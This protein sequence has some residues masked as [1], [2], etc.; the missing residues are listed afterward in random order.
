MRFRAK[1]NDIDC[2]HNFT[3]VM[4]TVNKILKVCV[5]RLTPE[6]IFFILPDQITHGG[7]SMWCELKQAN[8]F[9]VYQLDGY[10]SN[11]NE[12]Y[13]EVVAEN[14]CRALKS[15]SNA[16][17]L[18]IRLSRKQVPCLT[19]EIELPSL[20]STARTVTHDVPVSVIPR[21]LWDDFQEPE[22]PDFHVCVCMPPLQRVKNVVERLK[23]LSTYL[24]IMANQN[25]DMALQVE[26]ELVSARTTFRSL[27]IPNVPDENSQATSKL[28]SKDEFACARIDI[29]KFLQFLSGQQINPYKVVCSIIHESAVHFFIVHEDISLHYLI[30]VVKI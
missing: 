4:S 16:K 27:E 14:M 18:K 23:N 30:P 10:S 25:G 22:M 13:L 6:K 17:C 26:T 5:L 20:L 8:F 2:I 7:V 1:A 12:I 24:T 19:F 15:A 21:R 29:K 11:D 28:W 9:D 3:N